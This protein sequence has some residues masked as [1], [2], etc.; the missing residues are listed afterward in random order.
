MIKVESGD[1]LEL[2]LEK[3]FPIKGPVFIG[4]IME[5]EVEKLPPVYS[6]LKIA[7]EI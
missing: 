3:A 7:G 6:W 2:G 1:E 4:A 5:T